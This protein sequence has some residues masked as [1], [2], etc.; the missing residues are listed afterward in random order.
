M[1]SNAH[2]EGRARAFAAMREQTY[3]IKEITLYF[4]ANTYE[5]D[6]ENWLDYDKVTK[7]AAPDLLLKPEE[8]IPLTRYKPSSF[9]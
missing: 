3:R 8:I 5:S 4:R 2:R 1:L 7:E 9:A 6:G